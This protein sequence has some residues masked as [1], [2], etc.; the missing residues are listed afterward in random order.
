MEYLFIQQKGDF[1]AITENIRN[2]E[3]FSKEELVNSYNRQVEM[4]IVGVRAQIYQ[5]LSLNVLFNRAFGTSPIGIQ[6]NRIISLSGKIELK[7]GNWEY[8]DK[9]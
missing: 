4:G 3:H 1:E 6:D 8:V 2:I 5:I 7:E 9:S